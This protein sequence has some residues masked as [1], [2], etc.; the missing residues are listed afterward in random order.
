MAQISLLNQPA[1]GGKRILTIDGGGFRGLGCLL[2]L[3][4]IMKEVSKRS[5]QSLVPCEVFDLICGTSTGGLIAILLGRFGLD[6]HA[7]I[8]VY[9]SLATKLFGDSEQ[10]FWDTL[11]S[12]PDFDSKAYDGS[13]VN[14]AML[15]GGH[16]GVPMLL[17]SGEV[18][19][20]LHKTTKVS[21]LKR[22]S[23]GSLMICITLDFCYHHVRGT[24]LLQPHPPHPFVCNTHSRDRA[25]T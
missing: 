20:V 9:K 13:L 18:D 23:F 12:D 2:I 3:E 14:L 5:R 7:A 17:T 11:I 19:A 21:L 22:I 1:A 16:A 24:R 25:S 6:C 8:D 4:Q 15:H 10:K